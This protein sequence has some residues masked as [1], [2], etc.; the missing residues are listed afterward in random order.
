MEK[1]LILHIGMPKTG[2]SS[3]QETLKTFNNGHCAYIQL[4]PRNH[5][6]AAR[7]LSFEKDRHSRLR[8]PL[9]APDLDGFEQR[10][11]KLVNRLETF[12]ETAPPRTIFSAEAA[13]HFDTERFA[14]LT[15]ILGQRFG[16]IHVVGYIRPP[17][18][19]IHSSFQQV[20][21]TGRADFQIDAP[22]YRRRLEKIDGAPFV[23][24]V[25]L[26]H[27]DRGE[28]QGGSVVQDFLALVGLDLPETE[29]I[30]E[31]NTGMSLE[32]T[33]LLFFHNRLIP[34]P[35][36]TAERMKDRLA[37]VAALGRLP[38]RKLSL[39]PALWADQPIADDLDWVRSR[40][41]LDLSEPAPATAA[42]IR[43][44]EDMRLIARDHLHALPE[45][46]ATAELTGAET[47]QLEEFTAALKPVLL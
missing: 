35:D 21:K 13:Y 6:D 28:L 4:G 38:G 42:L 46:C 5:S 19:F 11:H 24:K 43:S 7:A 25:T 2:S 30:E 16:R 29:I 14:K 41:G 47:T 12:A 45:L 20:I 37:L 32:T 26:R 44:E 17:T 39:D 9:F 3:I 34:R 10:R 1:S 22:H 36:S 31:M 15:R 27:F 18:S 40:T 8:L 23:D 33:C